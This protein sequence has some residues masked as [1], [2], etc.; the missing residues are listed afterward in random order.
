MTSASVLALL[1]LRPTVLLSDQILD[2]HPA[3]NCASVRKRHE[4]RTCCQKIFEIGVISDT[5]CHHEQ[6]ETLSGRAGHT[7]YCTS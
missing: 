3:Y 4:V 2:H 7:H 1:Q 6:A 5:G